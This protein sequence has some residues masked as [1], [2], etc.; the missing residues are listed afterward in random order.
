MYTRSLW[1]ISDAILNRLT[2]NFS[3]SER[4]LSATCLM[5]ERPTLMPL[6]KLRKQEEEV[7][8]ISEAH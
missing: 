1:D 6:G 8:L 3:M 2:R 7:T 5:L 4:R